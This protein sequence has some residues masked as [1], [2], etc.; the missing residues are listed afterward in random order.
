M[1]SQFI[2]RIFPTRDG[3]LLESTP[4][5]DATV[6]QHFAYLK[7]L[8]AE[9][10][11]LL[12]GRTLHIDKTSHGMVVLETE[13][14]HQARQIMEGDPAVSAGVFRAELFPFHVAL[15]SE[16]LLGNDELAEIV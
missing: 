1:L 7:N 6:N 11:V 10:I 5:E 8:C 16:R 13:S 3:F 2:Y 14:E 4:D 15:A 9:G 12:A